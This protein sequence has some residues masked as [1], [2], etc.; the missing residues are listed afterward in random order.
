MD[1]I[2]NPSKDNPSD[3]NQTDGNP[4]IPEKSPDEDSTNSKFRKY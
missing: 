4:I 2:E 3:N 1:T